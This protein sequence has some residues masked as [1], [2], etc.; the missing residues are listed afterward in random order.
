MTRISRAIRAETSDGIQQVV[1]YQAGVG[2]GI[3]LKDRLL[4]GAIGAGLAEN[5]REAYSFIANNWAPG[6]E[7][8]LIGFSRG[9][10]T[11]RSVADLIGVMG[12]L[13]KA[14]MADFYA[15]FKDYQN[16]W[17]PS[18]RP[19]YPNVPFRNKPSARDPRYVAELAKVCDVEATSRRGTAR[20]TVGSVALPLPTCTSK[21]WGSGIRLVSESVTVRPLEVCS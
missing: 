13:T 4:G 5:I 1:Y 18:Y 15:I 11:A 16:S 6:D 9:A 12:L 10:Y 2:T 8:F 20:L 7:I 19:E 3:S 21:R 14:G 17:D